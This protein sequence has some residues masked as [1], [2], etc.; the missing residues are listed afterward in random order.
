M[1]SL[2]KKIKN[3]F[4][5]TPCLLI[6]AVFAP[7][8]AWFG[9]ANFYDDSSVWFQRSGSIIVLCAVWVEFVLF[10]INHISNPISTS[11]KSWNDEKISNTFTVK[12]SKAIRFL[13][14]FAALMAIV[15]TFI[16]GY[17]DIVHSKWS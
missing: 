4:W 11:G 9:F 2:D 17:G 13:K 7:I 5:T 3:Q 12:Y 8:S 10:N 1:E 6:V 16:W 14:Y 15:G